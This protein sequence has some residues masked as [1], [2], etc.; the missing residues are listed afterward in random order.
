MAFWLTDTLGYLQ[1]FADGSDVIDIYDSES[2]DARETDEVRCRTCDVNLP[3][4]G[5]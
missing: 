5:V 1:L 2:L 4:V 3:V